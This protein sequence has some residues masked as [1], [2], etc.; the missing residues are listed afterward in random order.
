MNMQRNQ[1]NCGN[2]CQET[3]MT[4]SSYYEDGSQ[5]LLCSYCEQDGGVLHTCAHDVRRPTWLPLLMA[6]ID[7]VCPECK[8]AYD[9]GIRIEPVNSQA[10]Q[11]L[12][13]IGLLV[14]AVILVKA[15]FDLLNGRE[16]RR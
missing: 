7:I 13:N 11:T 14:G 3:V 10:G 9:L 8:A 15:V 1:I 4:P 5:R 6:G 2:C 12:Q 16:R